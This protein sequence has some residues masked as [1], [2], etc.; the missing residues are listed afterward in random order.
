M[1]ICACHSCAWPLRPVARPT[2]FLHTSGFVRVIHA[3]GHFRI[4]HSLDRK[5]FY[6]HLDL[7]VSFV[8]RATSCSRSTENFFTHFWFSACHSCAGPLPHVP[9]VRLKTFLHTSGF[10]RV[11]RAQGHFLQPLD[12]KLFLHTSGFVRVIHAQGH[13]RMSR[14]FDR[15][16]FYALLDLCVSLVC[17]ETCV[18]AFGRQLLG[19]LQV[20]VYLLSEQKG[21]TLCKHIPLKKLLLPLFFPAFRSPSAVGLHLGTLHVGSSSEVIR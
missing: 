19:P 15:K 20:S 8:R 11:I 2:T 10:V 1:W 6:T 7:C 16:L 4:C 3:Q 5:L 17:R 9:F 12:R 14:S 13:F 18:L 21:A